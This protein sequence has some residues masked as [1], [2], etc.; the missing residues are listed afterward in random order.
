MHRLKNQ[1]D[2]III[3]SNVNISDIK[4]YLQEM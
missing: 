1:S 3:F 2:A 4:L